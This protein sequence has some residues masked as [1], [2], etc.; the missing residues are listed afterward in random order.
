M[1]LGF[2]KRIMPRT[3]SNGNRLAMLSLLMQASR[4]ACLFRLARI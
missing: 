3:G 2:G 1:A 4:F